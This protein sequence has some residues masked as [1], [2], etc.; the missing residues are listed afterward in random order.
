M[1][2]SLRLFVGFLQINAEVD[3]PFFTIRTEDACRDPN[4]ERGCSPSDPMLSEESVGGVAALSAV[5]SRGFYSQQK[6]RMM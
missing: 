3:L 4:D 5:A 2:S 1:F 6:C